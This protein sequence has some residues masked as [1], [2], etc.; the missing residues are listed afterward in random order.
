MRQLFTRPDSSRQRLCGEGNS[1][2]DAT[3]YTGCRVIGGRAKS[4]H[5]REY[6]LSENSERRSHRQNRRIAG[7]QHQAGRADEDNQ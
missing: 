7:W 4:E 6:L 3:Q 5:L 1:E 2:D